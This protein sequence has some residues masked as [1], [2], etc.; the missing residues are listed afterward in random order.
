MKW[1]LACVYCS[2]WLLLDILFMF[3]YSG[4]STVVALLPGVTCAIWTLPLLSPSTNRGRIFS[5]RFPHYVYLYSIT[6][7]ISVTLSHSVYSNYPISLYSVHPF[8]GGR[9]R[10]RCRKPIRLSGVRSSARAG[11]AGDA[12]GGDYRVT[13]EGHITTPWIVAWHSIIPFLWWNCDF[14]LHIVILYSL[15]GEDRNV[16]NRLRNTQGGTRGGKE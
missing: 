8:S 11:R 15:T 2:D 10:R 5:S 14:N 3:W 13:L 12:G 9:R 16:V 7:S 1:V 4:V 6:S